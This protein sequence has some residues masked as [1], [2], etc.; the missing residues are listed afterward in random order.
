MYIMKKQPIIAT[1]QTYAPP[2]DRKIG[3]RKAKGNFQSN[4]FANNQNSL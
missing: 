1:P 4:W 2:R 3:K